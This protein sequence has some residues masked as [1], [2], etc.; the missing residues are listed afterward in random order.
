[1]EAAAIGIFNNRLLI[2]LVFFFILPEFPAEI[3]W[4]IFKFQF[5]YYSIKSDA[6]ADRV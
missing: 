6:L 4:I 3:D 5:K 1:M 2:K